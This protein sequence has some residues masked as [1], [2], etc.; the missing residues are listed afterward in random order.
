[1][2]PIGM[3]ISQAMIGEIT[4]SS[5]SSHLTAGLAATSSEYLPIDDVLSLSDSGA[6]CSFPSSVELWRRLNAVFLSDL[7]EDIQILVKAPQ[8]MI[9]CHHMHFDPSYSSGARKYNV[10]LSK[11]LM[12]RYNVTMRDI[13]RL[14]NPHMTAIKANIYVSPNLYSS[15]YISEKFEGDMLS[16]KTKMDSLLVSGDET[17]GKVEYKNGICKCSSKLYPLLITKGVPEVFCN[18]I[19]QVYQTRGIIPARELIYDSLRRNSGVDKESAWIV[20]DYMTYSGRPRAFT[21]KGIE[22]SYGH[23][24]D[25]YYEKSENSLIKW[26]EDK[27][28]VVKVKDIYTALMVGKPLGEI[29]F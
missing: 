7:I 2:E 20:A 14:I 4:Q 12:A 24:F 18:D 11:K 26:L 3:S 29:G 5:L 16:L 1:M 19:M 13:E 17:I 15:L 9:D 23:M 27:D 21:K 28:R 22:G 10:V 6:M 25:M 8:W